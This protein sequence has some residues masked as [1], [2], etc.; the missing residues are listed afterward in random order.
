[1]HAGKLF[2][3][4]LALLIIP[5]A[6]GV[7]L[8]GGQGSIADDPSGPP[9]AVD[10]PADGV[11]EQGLLDKLGEDPHGV[12][13]QFEHTVPADL[14]EI[15]GIQPS[16]I[17]ESIPAAYVLADAEAVA[18]LSL[19]DSVTF[20]ED[21]EKELAFHLETATV[22]TRA[23][24]VYDLAFEP[25]SLVIDEEDEVPTLPDGSPYDGAGIGVAIID[26][27]LDGTH[28][29]F[30]APGKQAGNYV[31]TPVGVEDGGELTAQGSSHGT[32]IAS[33]AAGT[34]AASAA[35]DGP[36]R[37][38]AAPGAPLYT[39][40]TWSP[41][42]Q[43]GAEATT[44][45]PAMAFDWILQNGHAQD[46]AIRVIVN[47]WSCTATPCA[48][49]NPAQAHVQ[50]ATGLADAGY[51]VLFSVGNNGGTGDGAF[52]SPES[53]LA[54]PGILGI[55]AADDEGVGNRDDCTKSISSK[56]DAFTPLT[57]PDLIAPGDDV[58]T[59]N[60]IHA[61]EETRV[62]VPENP[63]QS[64]RRSYVQVTG[65]S[66]A[67]GHTGGVAALMLQANA[68]LTG[69]EIAYILKETAH[70]PA[71]ESE[72]CNRAFY[73]ADPTHPWGTANWAAG[74][75]ILDA[76]DAIQL[77]IDFDGI[78]DTEPAL[79][80]VP[81]DVLPVDPSFT[82][83]HTFYLSGEDALASEAPGRGI[84]TIRN[85]GPGG[86][87]VHT[88]EPLAEGFTA[89]GA[90]AEIWM[91]TTAEYQITF[92]ALDPFV[93][94]ER[95]PADGGEAELIFGE[96][97]PLMHTQ[98]LNPILRPKDALFDAPVTFVQGDRIQ[99]TIRVIG[100]SAA[101][102]AVGNALIYS[103]ARP[104]PSRIQLGELVER[105][106]VGS[107]AWCIE[108]SA[109]TRLGGPMEIVSLR[110]SDDF[111]QTHVVFTG[112][113]GAR[114]TVECNQAVATCTVPGEIGSGEV[115]TCRAESVLTHIYTG[116]GSCTYT[117]P[118]GTAGGFGHC[119]HGP[120]PEE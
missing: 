106:A 68:S 34:G 112:P 44:L 1:M 119:A 19:L 107:E 20:I 88:S 21:A 74:H 94:I 61:S 64:S 4:A 82:P 85:V 33:A 90:L 11:L 14:A 99:I 104:V 28:P 18:T 5:L 37:R 75:G 84:P 92:N 22:A 46:P 30:Q 41:A 35:E 10:A 32:H 45:A 40:A 2:T 97:M 16:Y 95:L 113:A 116:Q 109:C 39:F 114:A 36:D 24:E 110:C 56:G 12:I 115:G 105:P 58:W 31:V 70:K 80:T 73:Q 38:G 83:T 53:Q 65:T 13:V 51:L 43:G 118:D 57:W 103:D 26:S 72:K 86:T 76:V 102:P 93:L 29:D 67:A 71:G 9:A 27:G 54:T 100:T 55:G 120:L 69:E 81:E 98:P 78:P 52:T 79:E 7:A 62:P 111:R 42:D 8:G 91:G 101:S 49:A 25:P 17:F 60:A 89:D 117:L 108:T 6:P 48:E 66:I 59:A 77:A 23:K 63:A 87:L 47:A 50:L 3:I 96:E 15:P